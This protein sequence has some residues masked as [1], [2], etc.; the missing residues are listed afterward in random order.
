MTRT[1]KPKP[2][3]RPVPPEGSMHLLSTVVEANADE[4]SLTRDVHGAV[5]DAMRRAR[6][7]GRRIRLTVTA[8]VSR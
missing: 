3:P 6:L 1:P 5:V 7:Y 4:H 2:K 8:E